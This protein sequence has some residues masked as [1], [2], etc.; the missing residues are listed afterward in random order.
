LRFAAFRSTRLLVE[1]SF[2]G[3]IGLAA[4]AVRVPICEGDDAFYASVAHAL[5][6]HGSFDYLRFYGPVFFRAVALSFST[7]GFSVLALR[8]VSLLGAALIVIAAL[9]LARACGADAN[10]QAWIAALLIFS[11]EVGW[12]ATAGR[13]DSLAVGL[14]LLGLA[15]LVCGLLRADRGWRY[16]IAGG[17]LVAAAALTT[18]RTFPFV[19]VLLMTAPL[20]P[21]FPRTD[22]VIRR[23]A[24]RT[25]GA[26][27]VTTVALIA[28]WIIFGAGGFGAWW[29]MMWSIATQ[30]RED[31]TILSG[32]RPLGFAWWRLV[33]P[34]VAVVGAL[35]LPWHHGNDARTFADLFALHIAWTTFLLTAPLFK[36]TFFFATYWAVPLF[37]VVLAQSSRLRVPRRALTI[38]AAGLLTFFV[39]ARVAKHVR[40]AVTWAGRDP[41]RVQAFVTAHVPRGSVVVGPHYLYFFPVERSGSHFETASTADWADWTRWIPASERGIGGTP[42]ND[43]P[44]ARYL[45]WPTNEDLVYGSPPEGAC[46]PRE[47]IATFEAP[48]DDLPALSWLTAADDLRAYPRATLYRVAPD[49][50]LNY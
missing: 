39:T 2:L 14:E 33:T 17:A 6:A 46:A 3:A 47:A 27:S 36:L 42:A 31:I 32:F 22:A 28:L 13:M 24:T 8:T 20:I 21:I 19:A 11:P 5:P 30:Q 43:S 49:C 18:P 26:A 44:A 41:V 12:A 37:V 29:R 9:I 48:P 10:R 34:A 23:D 1:A 25:I 7:L 38:A 35:R 4:I 40:A 15:V 50:R 16:G 45:L